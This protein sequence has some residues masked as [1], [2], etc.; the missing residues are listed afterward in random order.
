M[1]AAVGTEFKPL[2]FLGVGGVDESLRTKLG[3]F[4]VEPVHAQSTRFDA[5]RRAEE[6]PTNRQNASHAPNGADWILVI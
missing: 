1:R 6:S 5:R 3:D 2:P 4:D